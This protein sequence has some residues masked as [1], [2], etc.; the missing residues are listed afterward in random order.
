MFILDSGQIQAQGRRFEE[1]GGFSERLTARR[2]E[3][4]REI[5]K[6]A[7]TRAEHIVPALSAAGWGVGEQRV[8]GE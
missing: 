4:R 8:P 1:S 6:A 7:E 3:A 5:R 2:V